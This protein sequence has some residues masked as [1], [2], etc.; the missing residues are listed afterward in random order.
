MP[1]V[2]TEKQFHNTKRLGR[3]KGITAAKDYRAVLS[4]ITEGYSITEIV[5]QTSVSDRTLCNWI[6]GNTHG[7]ASAYHAAREARADRMAARVLEIADNVDTS[8]PNAVNAAKLQCDV[9]K[10]YLSHILPEKYGDRPATL[11][12]N[13]NGSALIVGA[14]AISAVAECR[15]ALDNVIDIDGVENGDNPTVSTS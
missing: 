6:A 9:R 2:T 11:E 13:A 5:K 10:W 4:L 15:K 1:L 7:V 12:I 8:N 3:P 14:Q